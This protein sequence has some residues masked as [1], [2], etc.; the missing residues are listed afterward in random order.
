[1][2]V[3]SSNKNPSLLQRLITRYENAQRRKQM[4]QELNSYTDR[5]LADIGLMRSDIPSV[6]NG[7]YAKS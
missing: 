5:Q 3:Q 6:V 2:N 7:T 1:M 4:F